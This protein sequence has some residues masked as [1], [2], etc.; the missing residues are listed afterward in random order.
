MFRLSDI[1]LSEYIKEDVPYLDMTT[2]L[3]EIS[4]KP[5]KLEVYTREDIV[6]ACSEESARIAEL[7]NC[8]VTS[9]KPSGTQAKKGETI[10]TITGDY[11]DIQQ[12]LKLSQVLMEYTCKIATYS[13]EMKKQMEE[14][15]KTC[16]LL[17]TRKTLPF[18]KKMCIKAIIS[19]GA[20]P[21]RLGL[22]ESVLFFSYHRSVYKNDKEFYK[23][24]KEIKP[25]IPEKKLVVESETLEDT[26]ALLKAGVD[27]IQMDK[28]DTKLLK[29]IISYKDKNFPNARILAAGG[30]N[31]KNAK[32]YAKTGIDGIVTSAVYS[33][34]MANL[35]CKFE[36]LK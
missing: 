18:S 11:N 31:I 32:E 6:V 21:H 20:T 2:H 22:S 4:N 24:L 30:V 35:G 13:Y 36:V 28:V 29:E 5:T 14:V 1:E 19:G 8:K 33:C 16:E 3:Q 7:L 23:K 12:T 17:T 26:K 27:V 10:L 9:Y 25:K 34:G 15:N